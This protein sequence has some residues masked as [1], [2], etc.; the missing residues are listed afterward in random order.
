MYN[1]FNG[2]KLQGRQVTLGS[3]GCY[4]NE[5]GDYMFHKSQTA[6]QAFK[7]VTTYKDRFGKTISREVSF[8]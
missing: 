5:Y 8:I 2:W 4:R 6:R 1:T 3:K 7:K